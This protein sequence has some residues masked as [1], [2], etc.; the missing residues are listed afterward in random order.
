MRKKGSR[1]EILAETL[2]MSIEE[3]FDKIPIPESSFE[4]AA[5]INKKK[6]LGLDVSVEESVRKARLLEIEFKRLTEEIKSEPP[7]LSEQI[8]KLAGLVKGVIHDLER[9]RVEGKAEVEAS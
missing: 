1:E 2:G 9:K 8:D 3:V 7:L 5:R 4:L 6:A